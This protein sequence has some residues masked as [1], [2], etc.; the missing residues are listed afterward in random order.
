MQAIYEVFF[1]NKMR[2]R[3]GASDDVLSDDS[4]YP[5]WMA[6]AFVRCMRS[7]VAAK[8]STLKGVLMTGRRTGG[9]ALMLCQSILLQKQFQYQD[10]IGLLGTSSVTA[11]YWL[12]DAGLPPTSIP[13]AAGTHAHELSMV[14]GAL[15]GEVDDE[16]GL[17][18]SQLISHSL[19]FFLS[20]PRGDVTDEANKRLMPILPDTLGTKAFMETASQLTITHGPH[21]GEPFLSVVGTARQDSGSL[22]KFKELMDAYGFA[23]ALMASE[24]EVPGDLITACEAGYATFGA[25]GFFGDS[26]KAWISGAKN[27]SMAI[28]VLRVHVGGERT[29]A[30]PVKTGDPPASGS[31]EGKL[32][33]DG[34]LGA[35]QLQTLKDR[36]RGFVQASRGI[37][38]AK[39]QLLYR[40]VM[41]EFLPAYGEPLA[42]ERPPTWSHWWAEYVG[43]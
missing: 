4:W 13:R 1:R 2:M 8:A 31:G 9:L 24:V 26:E 7:C 23:G 11:H 17:P 10:S 39:L 42:S 35:E 14:M 36:T 43:S 38:Q 20:L 27:I 16:A 29:F 5:K 22:Q 32:E 3:Y 41:E 30:D 34:T 40:T 28:K 6:A 21:A 15:L 33:A 19:Y 37:D 25:G 18:L 12:K